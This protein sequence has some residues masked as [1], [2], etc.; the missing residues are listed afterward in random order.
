MDKE[1][2]NKYWAIVD[3]TTGEID[4]KASVKS[5]LDKELIKAEKVITLNEKQNLIDMK[6]I[7]FETHSRVFHA[8]DLPFENWNYKGYMEFLERRLRKEDNV[9]CFRRD[10]HYTKWEAMTVADIIEE[11]N[12]Y[13][14]VSTSNFYKFLK[15]ATDLG[16]IAKRVTTLNGSEKTTLM[17]NPIYT[18]NGK[19]L[20]IATYDTFKDDPSF[21]EALTQ[22]QLD[23]VERI[24]TSDKYLLKTPTKP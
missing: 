2:N 5:K 8:R 22:H 24:K 23:Q 17:V 12:Q 14:K 3:N 11:M 21:K 15:E 7:L 16:V 10:S 6:G 4:Y 9:V 19:H 1:Q 18:F 13:G 20:N